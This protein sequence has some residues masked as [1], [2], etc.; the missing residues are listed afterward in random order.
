MRERVMRFSA[1]VVLAVGAC[2]AGEA[3]HS[4]AE[5]TD[6]AVGGD[7]GSEAEDAREGGDEAQGGQAEEAPPNGEDAAGTAAGDARSPNGGQ[8][9]GRPDVLVG[10]FQI[11]L[12]RPVPATATG[13]AAPG[14][15]SFFG[16][17]FD[18]PTPDTTVWD[19]VAADGGCRLLTPRAPWCE[20]GC[21]AD[22]CVEDGV[23]Q[24]W[25]K[26]HAVGTLQV[27]G[28]T[29]ADGGTTFNIEPIGTS[30]QPTGGTL[31]YPAFAPA[32]PIVVAAAGSALCGPFEA[33][34]LGVAPLEL[35]SGAVAIEPGTPMALTWAAPGL[36]P[37]A[38]V[39]VKVDLSHHG[40][41]RG[42]LLCDVED[43][44][45]LTVPVALSD[46]LVGLG[47][48]GFPTIVITRRSTG[49]AVI[50]PG[51]VDVVVSSAVELPV[52]L[53]GLTS[54]TDDADCPPGETCQFDLKCQ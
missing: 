27:S 9:A 41:S 34:A 18:G 19:L 17:V 23:C 31:P 54:C 45:A 21:G 53:P 37:G 32:A 28:V 46:G 12:V 29:G 10:A 25:P 36:T 35:T 50:P 52:S 48:S 7:E 13:D 1:A 47:Y 8:G 5:A 22:A 40:G 43:T 42:L 11:A 44:G 15:T 24:P 14:Y 49:S 51:R 16:K 3:S 26:A 4:G 2:S 20:S 39:H 6:A 30:Y 38:V 33:Q